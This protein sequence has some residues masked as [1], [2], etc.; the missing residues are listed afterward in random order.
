MNKSSKTYSEYLYKDK[1]GYILMENLL[2]S[3]EHLGEGGT[4]MFAN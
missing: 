1:F 3:C 2:K 4:Q